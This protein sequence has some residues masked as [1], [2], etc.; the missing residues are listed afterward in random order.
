MYKTMTNNTTITLTGAQ[1]E[2]VELLEK[3]I[4]PVLEENGHHFKHYANAN[5]GVI[6]Y[7]RN[8]GDDA[9]AEDLIAGNVKFKNIKSKFVSA[10]V[11]VNSERNNYYRE[12]DRKINGGNTAERYVVQTVGNW[13]LVERQFVEP[14]QGQNGKIYKNRRMTRQLHNLKLQAEAD[15]INAKLAAEVAAEIEPLI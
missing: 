11:R 5:K 2:L 1:V 9:Q 8:L 4:T 13:E 14:R 15:H 6:E 3:H 10:G 7:H 12:V